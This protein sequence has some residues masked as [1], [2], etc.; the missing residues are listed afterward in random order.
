MDERL[1]AT[2]G[3]HVMGKYTFVTYWSPVIAGN[4][5]G[6]FRSTGDVSY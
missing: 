2:A 4:F 1:L 3:A 6:K 5:A